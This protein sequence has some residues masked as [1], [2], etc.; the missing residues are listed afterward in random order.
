MI[1]ALM[2]FAIAVFIACYALGGQGQKYFRH[3][4]GPASLGSFILLVTLLKDNLSPFVLLGSLLYLLAANGFAYGD[5]Q[6]HDKTW[7]KVLFRGLCGLS[8]GLCGLLIGVGSGH[9][10]LGVIQA[11]LATAGSIFFGVVNPL[12]SRWGN[13]STV[14]T[15]VCIAAGYVLLIPWMV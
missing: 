10:V 4:I 6:T 12:G 7:L 1:T 9:W 8:Y 14:V 11:I 3:W 15:D 2:L 5:K 13:W